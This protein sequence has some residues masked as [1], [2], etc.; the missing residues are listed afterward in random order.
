MQL[1][2][3]SK[4]HRGARLLELLNAET[5]GQDADRRHL[6]A[7]RRLAVPDG[8][9]DHHGVVAACLLHRRDDQIGLRLR[10]LHVARGRPVRGEL[11]GHE[12]V[13]VVLD[14]VGLGR[15][16]QHDRVLALLQRHQ[17][18]ARALERRHLADQLHVGLLLGVA[19][20]L[21]VRLVGLLADQGGDQLVAA[22]PDVAVD[23]PELH[24]EAVRAERPVP[25]DRVVVVRVDERAVDVDDRDGQDAPAPTLR[26]WASCSPSQNSSTIFSQNAG[27]SSGLREETRPWS[28]T[29]SS[30]THVPPALR[31]SV[32]SDGHDV[33]LRPRS[34]SASTSVH[35]PWQITPTGLDCSKNARAKPTAFSSMRRKSGFA[36]PPGSTSASYWEAS[37]S[38]TVW[39]T[40]EVSALS[41]GLRA[42][43]WPASVEISSGVPPA[44]STAFHG[45]VSSTC[46][47]PSGATRNATRFPSSLP[48]MSISFRS[49][50]LCLVLAGVVSRQTPRGTPTSW[51]T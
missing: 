9:A 23:Q 6:R 49:L 8:V 42:W 33:I 48:A 7:L 39:A 26:D 16:R 17:Q 5:A 25:G 18:L 51:L 46:S 10:L 34:T 11:A 4:H 13:E 38:S 28:T 47:M 29:T 27:R 30:S 45:S 24:D 20:A 44:S 3:R 19:D 37:G 31:M 2:D 21:A 35:G 1:D 36:T 32:W 12:Q 50:S 41:R 40:G 14:L 22:H 43:T 15:R